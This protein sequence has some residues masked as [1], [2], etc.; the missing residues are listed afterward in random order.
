MRVARIHTDTDTIHMVIKAD[1]NL[2]PIL[3]TKTCNV[4]KIKAIKNL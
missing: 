3:V 4:Q 2:P 1:Q